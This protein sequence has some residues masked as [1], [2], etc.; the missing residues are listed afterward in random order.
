MVFEV[1]PKLSYDSSKEYKR[2]M[3][4]IKIAENSATGQGGGGGGMEQLAKLSMLQKRIELQAKS[5]E[6]WEDLMRG[7]RVTYGSII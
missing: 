1:I 4:A 5:N 7:K 3:K 2:E 6:R